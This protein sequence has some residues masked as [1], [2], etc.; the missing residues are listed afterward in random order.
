MDNPTVTKESNV[1][2]SR[3]AK[4]TI[5]LYV[6]MIVTLLVGLYTS[7]VLLQALGEEDYG[8]YNVVGGFVAM[9]SLISGALTGSIS[10]FLTFEL[11]RGDTNA[12]KTVFSSSII[13]L[14]LLGF[15]VLC[16]GETF[17][18]WFL[19]N[20]LVIP[21]NRADAAFW[22]F[23][24]ALITFIVD[25]VVIPYNASIVSH[26]RLDTFAYL[27]IFAVISKL[28]IC[29]AITRSPIDRLVFYSILLC[30]VTL[31]VS[32]INVW[33]CHRNFSE[34]RGALRLDVK[35]LKRMFSFAGWSFIGSSGWILRNQGGTVL[36]NIFGG[37]VINAANAMAYALSS[38]A[39]NFVNCF[40]T[41]FNPQITKQ[42]AS[43]Q[44]DSLHKLLIY[45]AKF[46]FFMLLIVALPILLNTNFILE[47]WLGKVPD[48]TSAFV[49]LI[50]MVSLIDIISVPL[51]TVQNATGKIR[52]YQLIVG[53]IQLLAIPIAYVGLKMGA[54]VEWVYLAFILVSVLCFFA[55]IRLLSKNVPM[56]S[57]TKF[58]KVVCLKVWLVAVLASIIPGI[59][60]AIQP[61][62]WTNLI[63]TSVCSV[64]SCIAIIYL[65]GLNTEER[66]FINVRIRQYVLKLKKKWSKRT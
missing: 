7:R 27:S 26:E 2:Y 52:N 6:R 39:N 64:T 53:G 37:P 28:L 63:S 49:R 56:W 22:V 42:Y 31:I 13:V 14:F 54:P 10:R 18:L 59:V 5:I 51:I 8:I 40:T 12:L 34:S 47:L 33:Y 66:K 60:F 4:N 16:F 62:G 46:S 24:I 48:H 57:T 61:S 41:S 3:I 23:Q 50:L 35:L 11:G 65:V 15:I 9:F 20:K 17:G 45:G 32:L 1:N 21:T 55:R 43:E 36:L 29:F 30:S 44:Y 25:L 19:N 58:I 38:A